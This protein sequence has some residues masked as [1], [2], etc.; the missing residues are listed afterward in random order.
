MV[1]GSTG[2]AAP[3]RLC[4]DFIL[5]PVFRPVAERRQWRFR[6]G[7]AYARRRSRAVSWWADEMEDLERTI[8]RGIGGAREVRLYKKSPECARSGGR[9]IPQACVDAGG[10]VVKAVAGAATTEAA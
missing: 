2:F 10:R 1:S 5:T 9:Y 3:V 6:H 8:R 4:D 7:K